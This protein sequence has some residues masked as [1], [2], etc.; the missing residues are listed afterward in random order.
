MD[1]DNVS[2]IEVKSV[3]QTIYEMLKAMQDLLNEQNLMLREIN[4]KL[5]V[6]TEVAKNIVDKDVEIRKKYVDL[7]SNYD[8]T[9]TEVMQALE[10]W[11]TCMGY[12]D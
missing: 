4:E 6:N 1:M 9:P 8:M 2:K 10:V 5:T 12:Q 11:Q 7:I 3:W